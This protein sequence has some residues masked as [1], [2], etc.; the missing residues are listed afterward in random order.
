MTAFQLN[1]MD[2]IAK[3]ITADHLSKLSQTEMAV[4][5]LRLGLSGGKPLLYDEISSIIKTQTKPRKVFMRAIETM[6]LTK[7]YNNF[8]VEFP[9]ELRV[10]PR[11]TLVSD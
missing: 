11:R 3:I 1:K 10:M 6:G 5:D 7:E 2:R 9:D 4:V 8:H